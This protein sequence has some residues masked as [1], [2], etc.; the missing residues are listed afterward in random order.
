MAGDLSYPS[1]I[2]SDGSDHSKYFMDVFG[3]EVLTAF[4]MATVTLDKHIV[5][6]IKSG[7]SAKFPKTW[8]ASAE[9]HTPGQELLGNAIDTSEAIITVDDILVSH[10][11]LADVDDMMAHFDV[12][13]EFALQMGR[14]LARVFDKNVFRQLIL[15]AR[16]PGSSPF[17]GGHE[18]TD[19]GLKMSDPDVG[20]NWIQAI[21]EM[22]LN[23]FNADVP[24][25]QVR[26]LAVGGNT[27]DAIKY[28]K[29]ADGNYLVIN[30]DF[31]FAGGGPSGGVENRA[32]VLRIDG[33]EI[34]RTRNLPSTNEVGDAG[35]LDKYE[36]DYSKVLGVIWTPQ[37][38]GTVK[39]LDI[40]FERE[41]DVRRLEDFLLA[42]LLVGHGTLRPECAGVLQ[43]TT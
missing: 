10:T 28:A 9:Y 1:R 18:I 5:R 40:A 4:D 21:R 19:D 25:D 6:N 11:A 2:G 29:D 7:R 39:L 17:P 34:H 32:E 38:A 41:R 43:S 33:V 15:A 37:A 16:D 27:F 23:L 14:A 20:A 35:V 36:D 3:G 42:K 31:S 8:L 13:S 22:N 30:R 26:Y 12:R 24:E